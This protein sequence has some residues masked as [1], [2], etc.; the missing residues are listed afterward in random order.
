MAR[1]QDYARC[2]FDPRP[3]HPDDTAAIATFRLWLQM[4]E[5]DRQL[6]VKLDPEWRK[7]A[8]GREA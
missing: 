2:N 7:F 4:D 3:I 5:T 1:K 8:L 6:A